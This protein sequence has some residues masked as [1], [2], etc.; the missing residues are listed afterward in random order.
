MGSTKPIAEGIQYTIYTSEKAVTAIGK[1][2]NGIY[3]NWLFLP[4]NSEEVRQDMELETKEFNKR[5]SDY[6]TGLGVVAVAT[7]SSLIFL[8]LK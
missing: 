1:F 4:R 2:C 7:T 6:S 8:G 3:Y 5:I